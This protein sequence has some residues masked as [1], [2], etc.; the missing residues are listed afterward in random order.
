MPAETQ[1]LSSGELVCV[2]VGPVWVHVSSE[3]QTFM[4]CVVC[5]YPRVC[6]CGVQ[7]VYTCVFMPYISVGD[8]CAQIAVCADTCVCM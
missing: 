1:E 3:M 2:C 7:V 8:V 4:C 6:T 5:V